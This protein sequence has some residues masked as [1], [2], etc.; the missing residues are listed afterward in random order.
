MSLLPRLADA[1]FNRLEDILVK[2]DE[3]IT[4]S[5]ADGFLAAVACSPE[6]IPEEQWMA[7]LLPGPEVCESPA[8]FEIAASLLK[9]RLHEI[10]DTCRAEP[11]EFY[12]VLEIDTDDAPLGEIWAEGFVRGMSLRIETWTPLLNHPAC[13][14]M[15][16]PILALA[17]DDVLRSIEPRKKKQRLERIRM[18]DAI[19]ETV[20]AILASAMILRRGGNLDE[21]PPLESLIE[22]A[23][24]EMGIAPKVGRNE[25][26]PCGSG[27][28]FKKCCGAVA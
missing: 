1:E 5:S 9:R 11:A 23:E 2:E 13:A 26:C 4:L 24:Q 27:K 16:M 7:S 15:L 17:D 14:V 19:L 6:A 12:P 3:W 21:I 18:T 25:P 20:P 8:D 10:V 22:Q 28:K